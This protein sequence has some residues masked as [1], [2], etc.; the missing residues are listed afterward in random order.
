MEGRTTWLHAQWRRVDGWI[1][2]PHAL[3]VYLSR[4]ERASTPGL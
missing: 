1:E 2:E 4:T 3:M